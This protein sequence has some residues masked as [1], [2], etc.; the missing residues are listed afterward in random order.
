MNK[1]IGFSLLLISSFS[2]AKMDIIP[3]QQ[4]S[5]GHLEIQA[6]IN[7]VQGTFIVDTGATGTVIDLNQ[8]AK[9]GLQKNDE[10]MVGIRSGDKDSGTIETFTVDLKSFSV[11][12]HKVNIS[13]VYTNNAAE[14][15]EANIV[16]LIGQDALTEL[17]ALLD[18]NI[19]RL[20]IPESPE[21]LKKLLGDSQAPEYETI[22]LQRSDMGFSFVDITLNHH[23]L[24]L[25]VDSG[26]SETVMDQSVLLQL[27]FALDQH[28]TAKSIVAEGIELPMTVLS[29]TTITLGK[30]Q[31]KGDFFASDFSALMQTINQ[32]QQRLFVGVLGN[33]QLVELGS[34]ID[35]STRKLYI[36][37]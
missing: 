5:E 20:L 23:K 1:L 27:G 18:L 33:K 6:S 16:G 30:A 17:G 10:P 19:P 11:S 2:F 21:D 12:G 35:L 37:H 31:L 32:D 22:Q 26:A 24:R 9:F 29:G 7:G 13:R 15:F 34:I 4:T 8:L 25:L 36:K 28:P 14:Q 3:L